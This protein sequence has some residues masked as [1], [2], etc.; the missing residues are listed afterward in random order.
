[1]LED[2]NSLGGAHIDCAACVWVRSYRFQCVQHLLLRL[3]PIATG[4][5]FVR[6]ECLIRLC[7]QLLRFER[8]K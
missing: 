5:L 3:S 2:T 4:R 8:L 6:G 1:M 7:M